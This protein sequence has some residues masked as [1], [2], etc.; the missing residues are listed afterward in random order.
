MPSE[1]ETPSNEGESGIAEES[2][3]T[4]QTQTLGTDGNRTRS[5]RVSK[6]PERLMS[7][8]HGT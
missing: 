2:N 1:V 7:V 8:E 3:E 5:G 4:V 6:P